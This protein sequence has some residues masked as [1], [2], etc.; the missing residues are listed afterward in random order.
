MS[1]GVTANNNNKKHTVGIHRCRNNGSHG[2]VCGNNNNN[3]QTEGSP[4]TTRHNEHSD[5]FTGATTGVRGGVSGTYYYYYKCPHGG[6]SG[7]RTL[8]VLQ[9]WVH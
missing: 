7:G 5:G 4:T 2:V 8:P 3:D 6:V 1:G 9:E